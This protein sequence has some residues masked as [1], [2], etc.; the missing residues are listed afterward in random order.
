M[1]DALIGVL[2]SVNILLEYF[3]GLFISED[4]FENEI[5]SSSLLL[6]LL[7]NSKNQNTTPYKIFDYLV[8]EKQIF[9]LGDYE[10]KDVDMFLKKF[11][12]LERIGYSEK[13][14]IYKTIDFIFNLFL[15][16]KLNNIKM[17]YSELRYKSISSQY[18]KLLI[19]E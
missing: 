13:D 17:D 9:T 12:R 16:R 10:S 18:K 7:N 5:N 8:S 15:D 19:S 4:I 6:L 11:N 1:T 2:Q 14:K 3:P